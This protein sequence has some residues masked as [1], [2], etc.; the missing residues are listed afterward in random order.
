[1]LKLA[2]VG[3]GLIGGSF[4]LAAR[5]AGLFSSIVG[6]DQ[7]PEHLAQ[8][9]QLGICDAAAE[10][11]PSDADAVLV[12]LPSDRVAQSLA[13]LA[14]HQGLIFDVASVKA[15][16]FE[17]SPRLPARYVPCHP[18]AGSERSGPLAANAELFQDH[19]LV[20]TPIAQSNSADL[21]TVSGWWQ[22]LGARVQTMPAAEHDRLFARTSHLPHLVAFAYM[23]QIEEAQLAFAAGGFRDFSRI[24][25][26]DPDMWTPI[27]RMN[28]KAIRAELQQLQAALTELGEAVDAADEGPLRELLSTAR[29]R[30]RAFDEL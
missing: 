16:L 10:T 15:V 9:Q 14:Q 30:R 23:Q 5:K 21:A 18:I 22:A 28:R 27:L 3:V 24:A 4:A 11:V 12:A 26:S 1:M 29:R 25:A 13:S 8:A 19:L 2:V 7:D 17:D 20:M 6:V